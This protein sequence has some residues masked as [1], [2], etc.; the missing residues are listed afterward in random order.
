MNWSPAL[1]TFARKYEKR[2]RD[3]FHRV[4]QLVFES[5]VEGSTT[6]GAPGQPVDTGNLRGSW[7]IRYL[8]PTVAQISTG[9]GYAIHIENRV[10]GMTLRSSV[11]GFFSV[12]LT[13]AGF[14]KIVEQA[15]REVLAN[16]A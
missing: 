12:A 4:V 10:N 2:Q 6:T 9:V 16:A 1:Q 13:R 5:I 8:S 15:T 7:T 3:I 14:Q 11:G